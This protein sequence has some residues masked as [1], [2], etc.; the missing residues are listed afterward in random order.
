MGSGSVSGSLP[1]R[2]SIASSQNVDKED[3][4]DLKSAHRCIWIELK[5]ESP[6]E[7]SM[8]K[9]WSIRIRNKV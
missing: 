9:S 1:Q 4:G 5:A 3:K 6:W 2:K 8:L 7:T